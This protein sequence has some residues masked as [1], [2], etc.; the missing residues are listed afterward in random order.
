M[1]LKKI[2]RKKGVPAFAACSLLPSRCVLSLYMSALHSQAPLQLYPVP[3]LYNVDPLQ[4][5]SPCLWRA[6]LLA[7]KF[8][9]FNQCHLW[10][11]L[12]E[13]HKKTQGIHKPY[14]TQADRRTLQPDDCCAVLCCG[15]L[16]HTVAI[17]CR[18]IACADMLNLS[19]SI[20]V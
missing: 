14:Q 20:A 16:C 9:R 18:Q 7:K 12:M 13:Q 10:K 15:E 1:A 5:C 19:V 8:N 2:H 11:T 4:L 17:Q 3:R 6:L